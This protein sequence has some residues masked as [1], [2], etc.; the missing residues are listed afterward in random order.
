LVAVVVAVSGAAASARRAG[1]SCQ[2]AINLAPESIPSL[3]AR[4]RAKINGGVAITVGITMPTEPAAPVAAAPQSPLISDRCRAIVAG[5]IASGRA[6]RVSEGQGHRIVDSCGYVTLLRLAPGG[7]IYRIPRDGSTV[8]AGP[9]ICSLDPLQGGFVL[10]MAELGGAGSQRAGMEVPP[11][12]PK[13]PL[14]KICA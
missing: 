1:R 8:L 6:R 2:P 7:G 12:A 13:S 9:D 14:A 3:T 10:K 11:S 4:R 5:R